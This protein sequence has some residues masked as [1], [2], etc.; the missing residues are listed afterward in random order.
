MPQ[1]PDERDLN[2]TG[3]FPPD[4][5]T[6]IGRLVTRIC[7]GT[8]S[9][10]DLEDRL[11]WEIAGDSALRDADI[12]EESVPS[13]VGWLIDEHNQQVAAP[14]HTA[15][16]LIT[17]LEQ[18]TEEGIVF[19]FGEGA[20]VQDSLQGVS[21]AAEVLI[22]EGRRVD[23]YC[24]STVDDVERMIFEQRL[25]VAFGVFTLDGQGAT[26]IGDRIATAF[27]AHDLS[28]EWEGTD[29][30]RIQVVGAYALPYADLD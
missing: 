30:R 16:G 21:H 5:E 18:L 2:F 15:F 27:R 8:D 11:R 24:F 6:A 29:D 25:Y 10:Q 4:R 26:E 28:V 7:I 13:V 3:T 14:S 22:A 23:G 9:R 12:T 17:A 20:G 19:G 1:D